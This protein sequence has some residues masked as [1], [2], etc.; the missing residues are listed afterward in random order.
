M[1]PTT[2]PEDQALGE[3]VWEFWDATT[4]LNEH[5]RQ[6]ALQEMPVLPPRPSLE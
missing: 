2:S 5:R 1:P 6:A 3:A 4:E